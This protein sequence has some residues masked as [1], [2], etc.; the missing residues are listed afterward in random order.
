MIVQT[1]ECFWKLYIL[2][3]KGIFWTKVF[4]IHWYDCNL[5][6]KPKDKVIH[7]TIQVVTGGPWS[8]G[9]DYISQH[10]TV[11]LWSYS[12][13]LITSGVQTYLVPAA[14]CDPYRGGEI[15]QN[16]LSTFEWWKPNLWDLHRSVQW[17]D[18][19]TRPCM[20]IR[21]GRTPTEQ[22]MADPHGS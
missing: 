19:R 9:L 16:I 4:Y 8:H 20:T 21:E 15:I 2:I 1:C 14:T 17:K 12:P 18:L 22:V 3:S 13:I 7:R 5:R 6:W 10:R 11:V